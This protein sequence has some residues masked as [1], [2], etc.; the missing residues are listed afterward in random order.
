MAVAGP[1]GHLS[2][3]QRPGNQRA[4]AQPREP[5]QAVR[6]PPAPEAGD[7][8]GDGGDVV[9]EADEGFEVR[10]VHAAGAAA[11]AAGPDEVVEFAGFGAF[12]RVVGV[13]GLVGEGAFEG[14]ELGFGGAE[15]GGE[16][17]EA[18]EEGGVGVWGGGDGWG[19]GGG[20]E[21]G[22]EVFVVG[23]EVFEGLDGGVA[24]VEGGVFVRVG[25]RRGFVGLL[26]LFRSSSVVDDFLEGGFGQGRSGILERSLVL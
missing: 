2:R 25:V 1:R 11:A 26:F 14:G 8:H 7:R 17:G 18:G 21:E 19:W 24:E 12:G 6:R 5:G 23:D 20:G 15:G 4:G 13:G 3:I 9:A 10:G 22:G 16:V